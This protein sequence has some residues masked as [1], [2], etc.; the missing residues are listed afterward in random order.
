[1]VATGRLGCI[2]EFSLNMTFFLLS[3]FLQDS[4][5]GN[6][7]T[8]MIIACSPSGSNAFETNSSLRFGSRAKGIVNK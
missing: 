6:A 5:G 4:L 2:W 8:A 1:M 7:Q 3:G